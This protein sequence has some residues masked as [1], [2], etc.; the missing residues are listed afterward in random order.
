M[1]GIGTVSKLCMRGLE[2]EGLPNVRN[3]TIT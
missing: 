3:W 2:L 1:V